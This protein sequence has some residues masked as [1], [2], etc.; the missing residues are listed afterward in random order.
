M[1]RRRARARERLHEADTGTRELSPY[2][3]FIAN[4]AT[5]YWHTGRLQAD[6]D[7]ESDR[8]YARRRH[9][10]FLRSLGLDADGVDDDVHRMRAERLHA[11]DDAD[12]SRAWVAVALASQEAADAWSE[13]GASEADLYERA[14]RG[15]EDETP[16]RQDA[17]AASFVLGAVGA[18]TIRTTIDA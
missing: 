14:A 5:T 4:G 3:R 8:G 10:A 13:T 6:L 9:D 12:P 11:A 7:A 1:R 15:F 2:E 16:S 17:D 18:M